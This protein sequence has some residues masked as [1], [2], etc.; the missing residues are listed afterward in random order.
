MSQRPVRI[1][2]GLTEVS[3]YYSKLRRGF[4]E[5]GVPV[6]HVSLLAHGFRYD[7]KRSPHMVVRLAQYCVTHRVTMKAPGVAR[8]AFWLAMVL[9]TRVLLFMWAV[10]KFDVFILGGGSSF[11]GFRELP[12]LRLLGKRIVY[13]FH[14]TDA[15]PTYIDG[16]FMP[17][18]SPVPGTWQAR[19]DAADRADADPPSAEFVQTLHADAARRKT[20]VR[21]VER[22]ADV[23]ISF[24][25]FAHFLH[26]PCVNF[27]AIGI[28]IL[29]AEET[30]D[31]VT[32]TNMPPRVL[33]A[34]SELRGKGTAEI[35]HAVQNVKR[36]GIEIDYVEISG[37]PNSEV[38]AAISRC[39]FVIDQVYSD[40]PMAGFATEAALLG[41]PAIV[42][43]YYHELLHREVPE[44]LI[45]PTLCCH[46]DNLEAAIEKLATDVCYRR[47]LGDRAA[48]YVRNHWP[49]HKVAERYV[50]LIRGD[51]P[52]EWRF[53]G[54]Y[55]SYVHGIGLSEH[56]A[57]AN[58]RAMLRRFGPSGLQLAKKPELEKLFIEFAAA[59]SV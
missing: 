13:A 14:G 24:P 56:R 41:K 19:P 3:G 23:V 10:A 18:S 36:K 6:V 58:V 44:A 39:D 7:T 46:P 32:A 20:Q 27:V 8:R 1:F 45:P 34:P 43:S 38:L 2:L 57:R 5:L 40:T 4:E 47:E 55:V 35:R 33:H 50:R 22:H 37:R 59:D 12:L 16:F 17:G 53:D 30:P 21:A 42:G 29:L 48:K 49:A 28:P 31:G 9:L 26:G 11:F 51:I 25:T 15:R 54:R 52:E